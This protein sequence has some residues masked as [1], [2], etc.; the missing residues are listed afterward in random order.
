MFSPVNQHQERRQETDVCHTSSVFSIFLDLPRGMLYSKDG[1][2][3][4]QTVLGFT[5]FGT[6]NVRDKRLPRANFAINII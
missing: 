3:W 1:T 6:G 2:Q 5:P 4:A